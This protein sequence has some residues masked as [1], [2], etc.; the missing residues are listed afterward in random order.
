MT[1][2]E[3]RQYLMK[4]TINDQDEVTF[5]CSRDDNPWADNCV[6]DKIL[7]IASSDSDEG[8]VVC[9]MPD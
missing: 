1:V 5:V 7:H 2:A 3:L 4:P 6:V 9:F 8:G